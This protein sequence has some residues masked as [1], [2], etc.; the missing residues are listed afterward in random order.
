MEQLT[1]EAIR[2][3]TDEARFVRGEDYV[4]Y[5]HGLQV[6]D[7][8]ATASIQAKR[9]YVVTV[10]WSGAR[11]TGTCTCWDETDGLCKHRVA[12][13]LAAIDDSPSPAPVEDDLASFVRSL[14]TGDLADLLLAAARDDERLE[15]RL[16]T[17]MAAATGDS[18]AA[19]K[20]LEQAA[21]KVLSPRGF[22]D[23]RRSFDVA[24]EAAAFVDELEG[25]LDSGGADVVQPALLRSLSRLRAIGQRA[26][27]SG[28]VLG[29]L[30]ARALALYARAC[31]EGKVDAAKLARWMIKYHRE[32]PGWPE[33]ALGDFAGALGEKGLAVYRAEVQKWSAEHPRRPQD[34]DKPWRRDYQ[35]DGIDRLLV[36]LA[37]LDGDVDQAIAL[38]DTREKGG[39]GQ[40]R[41][42]LD[43]RRTDEALRR[44]DRY[45]E[46]QHTAHLPTEDMFS[47]EEII[48]LYLRHDRPDDAVKFARVEYLRRPD[49][50]TYRRLIALAADDS[51]RAELKE[52]ALT[53]A[54]EF[55][56]KHGA[57]SASAEIHLAE[58]DLDAAWDV[59][60]ELGMGRSWEQLVQRSTETH[61]S[62]CATA[63]TM[64]AEPLLGPADSRTYAA[65]AKLVKR[66]APLYAA[67]GRA[68]EFDEYLNLVR[69][70]Y[71]RRPAF[72][73]ALDRAGL[74]PGGR[75][76]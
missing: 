1:E 45:V 34:P 60:K 72:I 52:W 61:P 35:R 49:S 38:L 51:D 66:A 15:R 12:V 23:Y 46:N 40:I 22:V 33:L 56:E 43:A 17:R 18:K 20:R 10:S 30:E 32:S 7:K 21:S 63:L 5:V 28:G 62:E 42:L 9:V 27:D 37:D 2:S 19:A 13:A 50:V 74:R 41:R 11:V 26:D 54:R 69:S 29:T 31:R 6:G 4:R 8:R 59:T 24:R 73:A 70:E 47:S 48:D 25:V 58:D 64:Q 65:F 75:L 57:A 3:A 55:D 67:A 36:E 14:S 68:A 44:L 16:R 39:A 53:V 76:P 71:A